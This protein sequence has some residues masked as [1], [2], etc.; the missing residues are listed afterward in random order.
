MN[1]F[2]LL[3]LF[4]PAIAP[5]GAEHLPIRLYTTADGLSSNAIVCAL[6]DSRGF[7]WFCTNEG[8]SRFDGYTFTNYAAEQGLPG[9]EAADFLE[10]RD[11]E[12]WVATAGAISRFNPQWASRVAGGAN[13]G[14]FDVYRLA[15]GGDPGPIIQIAEAVDGRIWCLT[16]HNLYRFDSAQKIFES[17]DLGPGFGASKLWDAILPDS[18]GSLWLG[19]DGVLARRLAT[20]HVESYGAAEG[21]PISATRVSTLF[22]DR[23]RRLWVGT[24]S[25]G[26]WRLSPRAA[27]KTPSLDRVYTSRDG[28]PGTLVLDLMESR[29]GSLW[30]GTDDGLA[31]FVPGD[32][33][34]NDLFRTWTARHG[35]DVAGVDRLSIGTLAE[36]DKG[37]LWL[38]GAGVMRLARGP[39][40]TYTTLDGLKSNSIGSIFEDRA[41][42]LIAVSGDPRFR[43]LHV[44]DGERFA[45]VVPR[46]PKPATRFTWGSGQIHFQDHAGAWW[47]ATDEGLCRYPR[48]RDVQEL[49]HTLPERVFTERDGL[50]GHG[51]YSMFE[52]SRGDLWISVL[53][54][55]DVERW[56][57]GRGLIEKF[58]NGADGQ[59][60]GTPAVYA[61]DSAG[62]IWMG[63]FWHDLA[64]YRNGRFQV[65]GA[66]DGLTTHVAALLADRAG[67]IWVATSGGLAR[68]DEPDA[69]RPRFRMYNSR[70]GLSS[71]NIR[72]VTEDLAGRIYVCTGRGIDQLDPWSG[73][74]RHYTDADGLPFPG[75]ARVAYRDSRGTLWFGG[76]GLT[77]F[78]PQPDARA[79]GDLQIRITRVR[80]RGRELP[81]SEL[82]ENQLAAIQLR[83]PD[84]QVQ[85]DFASLNFGVG[86]TIQYQYRLENSDRDWGPLANTRSVTYAGIRPGS[87]RFLVRAVDATGGTS[88]VPASVAFTLLPPLWQRSW[89]LALALAVMA[90]AVWSAHRYRLRQLLEL[91]RVRTRIASDLHDDIG[92]S[93]T[94][95]AVLS[96]LARTSTGAD[97]ADAR[98]ARIADLSREL[99]DSMS[100]I[101]W[102][103]NPRRDSV[104]DLVYRMRRFASDLFTSR[105][106]GFEFQ[107]PSDIV[108]M[109]LRAEIRR[110]AFLIF[111]EGVHNIVR[112]AQCRRV[113]IN[114][115]ADQ[116][117]L[118]LRLSDDGQG[119]SAD[120]TGRRGHG[121][122][123]MRQ[124]AR[125]LGGQLEIGA[126]P[127]CG[128]SITLT[129]P[130]DR[131]A[132]TR[133]NHLNR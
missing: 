58:K 100:D 17:I 77:R 37:S 84:D 1:R 15:P 85:I 18:D 81:V 48:V 118:V 99:V 14:R 104:S 3:C 120:A 38:A 65:F 44:F 32:A 102:A 64:R 75:I 72:C 129:V 9:R 88:A 39:F 20:G 97:G 78:V 61:E 25:A 115:T 107:A 57:R 62:N 45:A 126:E 92:S 46:L 117:R 7:L 28:L 67:R 90:V 71:D 108:K 16:L 109:P 6:R 94:Q 66:A 27:P 131:K 55:D 60:L 89:F 47:V 41:G 19:G 42:R 74:V 93:L 43:Y 125:T 73:R 63:L 52:D 56:S 2:F 96:E 101:V 86:E 12:Y 79:P 103:I 106:I 110:E 21:L 76:N 95:I 132:H 113:E 105:S 123:S 70:S 68:V 83:P 10:T 5:L 122:A 114:L 82:G 128:T 127:G 51:I 33:H 31:E 24:W 54:A 22:K 49:A 59:P 116:H 36:D 130:L 111:K 11:G 26:L 124:R 8:L 30:L 40:T 87:Y 29:D 112:H 119:V 69:D 133:K 98:L 4:L 13:A 53:G 121:L 91:E 35:L 80:V 34:K 50:S 23:Q